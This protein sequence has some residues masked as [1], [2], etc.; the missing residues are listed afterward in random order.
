MK[1]NPR[2]EEKREMTRHTEAHI[3][4]NPFIGDDDSL[5]VEFFADQAD[6]AMLE[7]YERTRIARE[8]ASVLAERVRQAILRQLMPY[9]DK[10]AKALD[11]PEGLREAAEAW[12]AIEDPPDELRKRICNEIRVILESRE[13]GSEVG[14]ADTS[15]TGLLG[16]DL[17]IIASAC[18]LPGTL[19]WS[20]DLLV[21]LV[22]EHLDT[23]D[24]LHAMLCRFLFNSPLGSF[25]LK[26][27]AA[28]ATSRLKLDEAEPSAALTMIKLLDATTESGEAHIDDIIRSSREYEVY[29]KLSNL[30]GGTLKS[31][32]L[33][34]A[35]AFNCLVTTLKI[36]KNMAK[37]WRLENACTWARC[38]VVGC[39]FAYYLDPKD[40]VLAFLDRAMEA[41]YSKNFAEV[42]TSIR[43]GEI[44]GRTYSDLDEFLGVLAA[45]APLSA[46]GIDTY[47]YAFLMLEDTRSY[48]STCTTADLVRAAQTF[49]DAGV[50]PQF[51]KRLF[52]HAY[53]YSTPCII[54][55]IATFVRLHGWPGAIEEIRKA[56]GAP[57]P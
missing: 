46:F 2:D 36:T 35:K 47:V 39:L 13:K 26:D 34:S 17:S 48:Y 18:K 55:K 23:P 31:L 14:P 25:Q 19:T 40:D 11:D 33:D 4:L 41:I 5:T 43:N 29:N 44:K 42:I 24:E 30:L 22:Q 38:L 9:I 28:L 16:D 12:K 45:L 52:A 37:S 54:V 49:I 10:L 27:C 50:D 20:D 6:E 53:Y 21:D 56:L 51:V 1:N 57:L 8:K 15:A 32:K 3:N 7:E